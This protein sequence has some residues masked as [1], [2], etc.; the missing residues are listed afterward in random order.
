[1]HSI[2]R[3][4][5]LQGAAKTTPL[6]ILHAR[7]RCAGCRHCSHIWVI[8]ACTAGLLAALQQQEWGC[9]EELCAVVPTSSHHVT[10]HHA[11]LAHHAIMPG[12][13]PIHLCPHLLRPLPS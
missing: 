4:N 11:T 13:M 10:S 5:K 8:K 2:T 7:L 12:P 6:I 3:K 1:M 9:R